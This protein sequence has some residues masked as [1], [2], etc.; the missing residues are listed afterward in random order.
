[1]SW[2]TAGLV[3]MS[4][5]H[6]WGLHPAAYLQ[7]T[8]HACSHTCTCNTHTHTR[9]ALHIYVHTHAHAAHTRMCTHT[10][11][12]THTYACTHI[13]TCNAHTRVRTHSGSLRSDGI[14]LNYTHFLHL[15]WG[16]VQTYSHSYHWY[17]A[18]CTICFM[19]TWQQRAPELQPT[20]IY[21]MNCTLERII[22]W[23][24][25]IRSTTMQLA[26]W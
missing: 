21:K 13:R 26:H 23:L 22:P 1:M 7:N 11:T 5:S 24:Q 3:Q 20:R 25:H 9:N 4:E 14:C 19:A 16:Q 10:H 2:V 15:W 17:S 6:F 8:S 12:H 18:S